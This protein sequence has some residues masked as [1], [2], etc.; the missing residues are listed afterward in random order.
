MKEKMKKIF[1]IRNVEWINEHYTLFCLYESLALNLIIESVSRHSVLRA[2]LYL[3]Q[4]PVM[5]VFNALI[6]L[7]LLG[8]G[9]IF[10][11]R[12][13]YNAII[14]ILL[15]ALGITNG[16]L[17]CFR[18][19]PFAAVDFLLIT[20]A[21]RIVKLYLSPVVIVLIL[22]A[23]AA[24]VALS[25]ALGLKTPKYQGKLR[26]LAVLVTAAAYA[27]SLVGVNRLLI[28][29]GVATEN[30][31]NLAD[32]YHN[33]GF[34]YCFVNSIVNLGMEKPDD[35]SPE[36]IENVVQDSLNAPFPVN[37]LEPGMGDDTMGGGT[38]L[39]GG[40]DVAPTGTFPA[41]SAGLEEADEQPRPIVEWE[42][43]D[44]PNIIFVQ[45]ESFFD[46]YTVV[47]LEFSK[48]PIPFYRELT[49]QYSSGRLYVPSVG[50]GTANTEFEI[51]TGMNLDFF[52]P[53]EYPYK[54]IL[55]STTCESIATNLK[56]LGYTAH[57]IHNNDGTFYDRH[58]VF[59]QLGFDTFT[60]IEYMYDVERNVNGFCRDEILVGEI[61]KAMDSTQ[62]EDVV[63]A[64]SVQAHGEYPSERLDDE[65]PIFIR[66]TDLNMEYAW[67]YYV[68]QI[69]EDDDFV[70]ELVA[71]LE[72]RGEP[73]ILVLY[74]DHLPYMN[75]ETEDVEGGVLTA[76][77]YVIWDNIGLDKNDLDIEAYQLSAKVLEEAGI[78]Q[79]I[80]TKLHQSCMWDEDYLSKLE[81]LQYD[82]LYGDRE[83]YG[84][85]NPYEP[86]ELKLGIDEIAVTAVTKQEE[87]VVYVYG[88]GFN[89]YS[90]VCINGETQKTT[91]V[92]QGMLLIE[93]PQLAAGDIVTV[94][95]IGTDNITLGETEGYVFE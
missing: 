81:I 90:Y 50:A 44:M 68:N 74:G 64:I 75:L 9:S 49:E 39:T 67:S 58:I 95:Q 93:N 89:E 42:E 45:L 61:L 76:T 65:E 33:Y 70:R 3:I 34:P 31:S 8:I 87:E 29:C 73:A 10:R 60:P 85:I 69:A 51:L 5:F 27:F 18:T 79:G 71:A 86:T 84:G 35:Y 63:Y 77:E 15:L 23:I 47:G 13:M 82:M 32:A 54:T 94:A 14:F 38:P 4:R 46:P 66:Y 40:I 52:G 1:N 36:R 20:S 28:V 2:L 57:A 22:L 88:T 59:S 56:A 25:I 17:L 80:L 78:T 26:V 72:E 12:M 11:R 83:I 43:T 55:K 19:T 62:G 6:L 48:D 30:F 7:L 92:E 37:P 24:A 91:Y 16:I 21:V 41:P 53:G